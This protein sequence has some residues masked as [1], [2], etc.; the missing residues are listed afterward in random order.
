LALGH[1]SSTVVNAIRKQIKKLIHGM[2][3]V[4]PTEE[5]IKLL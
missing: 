2:G 1:S 3:D 4:H 5:K